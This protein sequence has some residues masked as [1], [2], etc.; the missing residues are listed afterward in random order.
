MNIPNKINLAHLS[1][2]LEKLKFRNKK[3]LIKRD[4]FTGLDFSGN[5]LESLNI[6]FTA[7]R[8]GERK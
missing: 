5:K 4:D 6:F 8:K 7:Q 3:F 1:T 2:P